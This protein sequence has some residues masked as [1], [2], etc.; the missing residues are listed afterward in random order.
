MLSIVP[1]CLPAKTMNF[2]IFSSRA[3]RQCNSSLLIAQRAI[4]IAS[5]FDPNQESHPVMLLAYSSA[6]GSY[7]SSRAFRS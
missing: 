6:R 3:Y 1:G 7:T 2:C 5:R 4:A